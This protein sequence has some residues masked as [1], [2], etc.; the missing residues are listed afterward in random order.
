MK[1]FAL[2][3]SRGRF[4][5]KAHVQ[6]LGEDI[7]FAIWG[8]SRPHI[9]AVAAAT[10][11]PSLMDPRKWSATSSNFTFVGHKEDGL[12]RKVSEVMAAR[13]RRNVVVA[14]GIHWDGIGPADIQ[15]IEELAGEITVR[16]LQRLQPAGRRGSPSTRSGRPPRRS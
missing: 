11:R 10:P 6:E 13:L 14:A 12:V 9:G 2:Q 7:L 8:G 16:A 1:R 15:I 5:L 4:K 3:S